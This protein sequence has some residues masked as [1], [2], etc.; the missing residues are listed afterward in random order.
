MTQGSIN[1]LIIIADNMTVSDTDLKREI[2][3]IDEK[4]NQGDEEFFES[5]RKNKKERF[6]S[7]EDF[8]AFW[9]NLNGILLL[10]S[11]FGF[12]G[13]TVNYKYLWC[14]PNAAPIPSDVQ[15]LLKDMTGEESFQEKRE[16]D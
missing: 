1:I 11:W 7:M 14:N 3:W 16:F 4:I 13:D 15:K 10:S 8:L 9:K 6:E 2:E 5:R 12:F